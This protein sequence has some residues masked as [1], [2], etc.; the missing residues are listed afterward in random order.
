MVL[1]TAMDHQQLAE[2]AAAAEGMVVRTSA[3]AAAGRP[4]ERLACPRC[5]STDTKFCYYNNYNLQQPRHF[6]K[7][8]RRYWTVG[9][10]LRNVPVGGAT[11]SKAGLV[12]ASRR[13]R[14]SSSNSHHA[15][16]APPMASL[17][18]P[19]PA[20][21]RPLSVSAPLPLPLL[22]PAPGTMQA[23]ELSFIPAGLQLHAASMVDPDRRLLDLGGSFSSLLAPPPPQPPLHF[24][25]FLLGGG[26]SGSAGLA[27]APAGLQQQPVS[28]ALP[29]GFWGMGWP[30]LSI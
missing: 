4:A 28:Q 3:A 6:C 25:G 15:A 7:G 18:V 22:P 11:R 23:Y 24:G 8:C 20:P 26:G 14:S 10:A 5:E 9:G 21:V 29:E 12:P 27:H 2:E 17:P 1:I 19:V 13:K 16:P 30:D